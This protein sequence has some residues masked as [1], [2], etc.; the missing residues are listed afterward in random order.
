[1]DK[2]IFFRRAPAVA[3]MVTLTI[4]SAIPGDEP[5]L[6]VFELN[7]KIK[8]IIAYLVLG[9]SLCLWIPDKKWLARPV[10]SG[11]LIAAICTVFGIADEFHQS[12][13]PGRHGNDLGDIIANAIGG[14]LSTFVY[15]SAIKIRRRGAGGADPAK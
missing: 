4:L 8:H 7:D 3:I 10:A 13:T 6:F 11:A 2:N 9:L 14:L 12:F 1:M 15:F 5:V